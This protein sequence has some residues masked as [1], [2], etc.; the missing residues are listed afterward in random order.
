MEINI[1]GKNRTIINAN[2]ND[3]LLFENSDIE[4]NGTITELKINGEII[5]IEKCPIS[6]EITFENILICYHL[7]HKK[8]CNIKMNYNDGFSFEFISKKN[9]K[10]ASFNPKTKKNI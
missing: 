5:N 3:I 9:N 10:Y 8:Y 4:K 7:N 1:F 6:M 2:I